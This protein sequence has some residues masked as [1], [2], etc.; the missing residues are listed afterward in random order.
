MYR[1]LASAEII[2]E[3]VAPVSPLR[4]AEVFL[5]AP[6]LAYIAIRETPM[7]RLEQRALLGFTALCALRNGWEHLSKTRWQA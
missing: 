1:G 5:L 2:P 6:Y 7:T 4:L 3:P